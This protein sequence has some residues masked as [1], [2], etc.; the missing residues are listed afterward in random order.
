VPIVVVKE[1]TIQPRFGVWDSRGKHFLKA[2]TFDNWVVVNFARR[3]KPEKI[4][5][6]MQLLVNCAKQRG[7]TATQP[8]EMMS[9]NEDRPEQTLNLV[10]SK[11]KNVKLI[12]CIL[13]TTDCYKKVKCSADRNLKVITQCIKSMNVVKCQPATAGNLIYKINAKLG[14]VNH[15][16]YYEQ[17]IMANFCRLFKTEHVLVMGADVNHPPANDKTTP[18]LVA[19]VGSIDIMAT[20][21]AIEVRHQSHR[22][23][24]IVDMMAITKNLLLQYKEKTNHIP[25]RIIMYRDG[26]SETQFTQVLAQEMKAMREACT[27]LHVNYT[28]AITFFCVQKRHHTRLYCKNANEADKSGNVP[29]GTVV[30]QVITHKSEADF[31]LCSHQGLQGTSKP[32]HYHVLWDDSSFSMDQLQLITYCLCHN[33][34]RCSRAV[35]MPTP[36]YYAHLAAFRAKIHLE[37]AQQNHPELFREDAGR[38]GDNNGSYSDDKLKEFTF[39]SKGSLFGEKMFYV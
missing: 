16:A 6:F 37:G 15:D 30:D 14:G 10:K 34:S 38:G 5:A 27:S 39:I 31:F 18:S 7:M 20:T 33:Y 21:Y 24:G 36:A 35:S 28:P 9:G 17:N 12:V 29:A 22:V 3:C 1:A 8:D 2:A 11:Y 25:S 32:S 23:E 13:E 26:V 19:V 4:S